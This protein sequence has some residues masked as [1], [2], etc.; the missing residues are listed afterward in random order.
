MP[1]VDERDGVVRLD[2]PEGFRYRSFHT[3]GTVLGDGTPLP[4]RPDGMAAFRG[5]KGNSIIVRNHEINGPG[6]PMGGNGAVYDPNTRG[7]TVTVEVD[8]HGNVV[9]GSDFV[10]LRGTQ[11]NCAG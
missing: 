9:S 10:S 7:G 6:T 5:R 3:T 1:T 8:A 4:G 2:L 11:N